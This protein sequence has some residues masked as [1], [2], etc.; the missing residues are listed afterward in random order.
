MDEH[1]VDKSDWI[2]GPWHDEPDK[3]NWIDPATDLDCMIA[4]GPTGALCGY[5]AVPPGHPLHGSAYGE[6]DVEVHG[7][8][9]YAEKCAGHLCHVPSSGRPDDV[10]WF[11]FD[12]AHLCDRAPGMESR[13]LARGWPRI[14]RD[15]V[16][17]DIEYVRREVASLAQQLA[18]FSR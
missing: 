7:G 1:T 9:T 3:V 2:A 6:V 17:R 5:V 14:E 10:W 18:A 16:Y 13:D 11:G 4:R 12:C 15:S 8:L